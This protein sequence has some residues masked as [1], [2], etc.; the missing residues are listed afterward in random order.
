MGMY[1]LAR[2]TFFACG[3]TFFLVLYSLIFDRTAKAKYVIHMHVPVH[4]NIHLHVHISDKK[5]A[6]I[7]TLLSSLQAQGSR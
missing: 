1:T 4:V 5:N 2:N 6:R 7:N 3:N